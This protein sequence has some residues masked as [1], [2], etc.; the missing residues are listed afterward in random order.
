MYPYYKIIKIHNLSYKSVDN[1]NVRK[2][3]FHSLIK[4]HQLNINKTEKN[5]KNSY[6]IL[7]VRRIYH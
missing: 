1:F 7:V 2:T 5:H 3:T 6:K 4:L